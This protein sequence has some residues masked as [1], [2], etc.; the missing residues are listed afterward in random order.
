MLSN[1]SFFRKS[2]L[3]FSF[4]PPRMAATLHDARR[5]GTHDD[6][7]D[8]NASFF[9]SYACDGL[10]FDDVRR[11][12]DVRSIAPRTPTS[13]CDLFQ[14]CRRPRESEIDRYPS[15][16]TRT[17]RATGFGAV[18]RDRTMRENVMFFSASCPGVIEMSTSRDGDA[19][20]AGEITIGRRRCRDLARE[21][22][23][24]E[25]GWRNIFFEKNRER[26]IGWVLWVG[27]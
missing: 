22:R 2:L 20:D 1:I 5:R 14:M 17:T 11:R 13:G 12:T 26:S 6:D 18:K 7:D 16:S 4:E 27:I 9:F 23:E 10:F 8:A 25:E 15:A 21:R 3:L 19:G 24:G